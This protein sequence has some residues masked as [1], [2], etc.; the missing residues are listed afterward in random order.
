MPKNAKKPVKTSKPANIRA[1]AAE[2]ALAQ[3][4]V[5]GWDHVEMPDIATALKITTEE[6]RDH[7]HDKNDLLTA[8]GHF[9]DR[10]ASR[11]SRIDPEGTVRDNLFELVMQRF[12]VMNEHRGGLLSIMRE[13][14]FDPVQALI[15]MPGLCQ[16]LHAMLA[17]AG[18]NPS[19][20]TGA[21]K[22]TGLGS[23][24]LKNLRVWADDE[25]PDLA[26]TMAALDKNLEWGEKL[27]G[28]LRF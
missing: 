3:A 15:H 8:I 4:G 22:I 5:A 27:A 6:L 1:A 12:E 10:Q 18:E 13:L 28:F 25:S 2:T 9:L 24:F 11:E 19:G 17:A 20:L 26:R 23:I 16:S 7:V 21:L 14:K